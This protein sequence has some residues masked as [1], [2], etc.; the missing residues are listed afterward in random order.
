MK[1]INSL[2]ALCIFSF[3]AFAQKDTLPS[4]DIFLMNMSLKDG[5]YVFGKPLNITDRVGYD[6]QPSFLS[7]G[8]KILYSSIRDGKQTD[9]FIYNIKDS[10]TT[11][12]IKSSNS[13][14]SP[15]MMDDGNRITVVRVDDDKAQRLYYLNL[16][17]EEDEP[18][19]VLNFQDSIAYYAW[20]DTSNIA[21]AMLNG[22]IM[23]L[24]IFDIP[25]MQFIKLMSNVGRCMMNIPG[26][27]EFSFTMKTSDSTA[28]IYRYNN[29]TSDMMPLCELP[30]HSEDYAFTS[31]GKVITGKDGKLLM[32]DSSTE[33]PEWIEIADFSKTIGKFY[34]ISV[35]PK[36]DKIALVAYEKEKEKDKEKDKEK[37]KEKETKKEPEKK[38]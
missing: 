9:I 15:V 23:D 22:K 35:S 11:Q 7:T 2:I 21:C 30:L 1:K 19:Q 5:K 20:L 13:E 25:S 4:T 3:S 36:G 6:N 38:K 10:T 24:E 33:K 31:E 27:D 14:Y 26:T 17:E 37:E 16:H 18:I 32:Y 29:K 12:L 34:R 8:K 28:T